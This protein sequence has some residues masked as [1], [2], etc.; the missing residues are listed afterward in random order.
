MDHVSLILSHPSSNQ[1]LGY[2]VL[3]PY[4][5]WDSVFHVLRRLEDG[6]CILICSGL[7]LEVY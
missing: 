3:S 4:V 7:I 6:E 2:V 1:E 5:L